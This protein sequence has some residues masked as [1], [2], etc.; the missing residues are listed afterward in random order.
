MLVKHYKDNDIMPGISITCLS[1]KKSS[2]NCN[3]IND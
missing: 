3:I 1:R 2:F